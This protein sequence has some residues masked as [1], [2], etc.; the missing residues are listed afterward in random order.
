MRLGSRGDARTVAGMNPRSVLSSLVVVAAAAALVAGCGGSGTAKAP[1]PS[2]GSSSS[3]NAAS[4]SGSAI[5]IDNFA[6]SPATLTVSGHSPIA[7]AN[8][9]STAHTFTADDGHSFDT[10]PIDTGASTS[11]T[12]PRPGRYPYHCTIHPFMHGTLVVR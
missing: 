9:D 5:K 7:V 2:G 12:A 8:D 4:S 10:G 11:V 3:S 6:F 1:T